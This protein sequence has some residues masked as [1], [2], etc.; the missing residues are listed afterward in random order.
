MHSLIYELKRNDEGEND[1]YESTINDQT[2]E[3]YGMD[4]VSELD[5][6]DMEN[7][8]RRLQ[9]AYFDS[10]QID[11]ATKALRFTDLQKMMQPS[12]DLFHDTI[13]RLSEKTIEEFTR[14]DLKNENSLRYLMH[15]LTDVAYMDKGGFYIYHEGYFMPINEFVRTYSDGDDD[16]LKQTF[17]IGNVLDYHY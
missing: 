15:V 10:L 1:L 14:S 13:T 9:I 12:F 7:A 4:C 17:Y 2:M 5:E 8:V 6:T 3:Y 11:T 16:I